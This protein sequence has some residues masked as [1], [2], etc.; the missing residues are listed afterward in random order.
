[1]SDMDLSFAV[2]GTGNSGHAFAAEIALK[3][4]SVNLADVPQFQANLDGIQDRGGIEIAGKAGEGF[5][6]LNMV[7]TDLEKA[8]KGVDVIILG[9]PANAHEPYSRALAPYFEDDQFVVF[10]SNFGALRFQHWMKQLDVK[11]KVVPVETQSLIYATR[12]ERPGSVNVYAMKSELPTAALPAGRT[13]EFIEKISG[14]FPQWVAAENVLFTS[15]NNLNPVVHPTMTLLNAGRIEA[16]LG[17]GWNLYAEGAT[18]SVAEVMEAIEAERMGLLD[19]LGVAKTS[20]RDS[21]MSMYKHYEHQAETLSQML[22]TSPVHADP[23]LPGTPPTVHYRYVTEDVPFGMV[24]WSSMGQ[25]WGVPT[26]TCDA[27]IQLASVVEGVNYFEKGTTVQD[28][29]IA[30]LSPEQ[31]L[32]LVA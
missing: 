23:S 18:D 29:G 27:I 7:T 2:L 11:A 19:L 10:V 14:I 28:M 32:E 25:T 15:L 3:G 13:S 12:S 9:A 31:V 17:E 16:T 26:P 5:A 22:R 20:L 30:G 21:F 1:M 8:I 4:F 24:P 6:Q